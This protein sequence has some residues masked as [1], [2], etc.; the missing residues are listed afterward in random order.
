MKE[1]SLTRTITMALMT[2]M[3]LAGSSYAEDNATDPKTKQDQPKTVALPTSGV[4][5]DL[6]PFKKI[7]E[8]TLD[9]VKKNELAQAKT[10][11][12]NLETAWDDAEET[13]KPKSPEKWNSVDKSIDR[14]LAQ[15][16]S[17]EPDPAACTATLKTVIAKFTTIGQ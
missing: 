1:L 8:D 13:M 4:L 15:L 17:A 7:A 10:R 5:G 14:A 3:L 11:I 2:G 9:L 12:K 6:S 16:R